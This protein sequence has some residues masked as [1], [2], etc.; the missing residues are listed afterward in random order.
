MYCKYLFTE[1]RPK[2]YSPYTGEF[3]NT[4]RLMT[5]MNL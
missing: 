1:A 2:A 5:L 4:P 3:F